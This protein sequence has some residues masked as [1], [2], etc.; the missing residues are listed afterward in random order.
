MENW[1][2]VSLVA[3]EESRSRGVCDQGLDV[4]KAF[5]LGDRV[6]VGPQRLPLELALAMENNS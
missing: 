5:I 6:H 3:L 4:Q 1:W 2:P